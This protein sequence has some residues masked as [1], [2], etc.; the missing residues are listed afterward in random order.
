MTLSSESRTHK[1]H[2]NWTAVMGCTAWARRIS[3]G[4]ASESPRYFTFPSS[5]NFFISPI[6]KTSSKLRSRIIFSRRASCNRFHHCMVSSF[7]IIP[8][9]CSE[10]LWL[11]WSSSDQFISCK[12]QNNASMAR[13]KTFC[14]KSFSRNHDYCSTLVMLDMATGGS[15]LHLEKNNSIQDTSWAATTLAPTHKGDSSELHAS[16]TVI[17]IWYRHGAGNTDQFAQHQAFSSSPH[18]LLE[19][20]PD[21]P[22][23]LGSHPY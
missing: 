7:T 1:D 8:I 9:S 17:S 6:W 21:L 15:W 23:Q 16:L 18:K 11:W 22:E 19:H 12:N 14:K 13:N 5:T 20:T 2:S 10:G 4:D 3:D